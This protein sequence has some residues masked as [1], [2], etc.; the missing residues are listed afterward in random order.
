VLDLGTVWTSTGSRMG[1][2]WNFG[3]MRTRDEELVVLGCGE[4]DE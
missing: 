4:D 3:S 2:G 1:R